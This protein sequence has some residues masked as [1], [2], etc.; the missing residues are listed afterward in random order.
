MNSLLVASNGEC[1]SPRSHSH[2]EA[3]GNWPTDR[4]SPGDIRRKLPP[5][6]PSSSRSLTPCELAFASLDRLGTC[7]HA[8]SAGVSPLT[9]WGTIEK[10]WGLWRES[11]ELPPFRSHPS[12][13]KTQTWRDF[14]EICPPKPLSRQG[15]R[16]FL[17]L[18]PRRIDGSFAML[19]CPSPSPTSKVQNSH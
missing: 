6:D 7:L 4:D 15:L 13:Q 3:H 1:Y 16:V 2:P 14:G 8:H 12:K 5:Q 17:D 10:S 19:C 11:G 9:N 18:K